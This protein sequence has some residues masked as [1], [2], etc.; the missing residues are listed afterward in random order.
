MIATCHN[1]IN[2]ICESTSTFIKNHRPEINDFARKIR[3]VAWETFKLYIAF[4]NPTITCTFIFIG[5]ALYK[6]SEEVLDSARRIAIEH[7]YLIFLIVIVSKTIL[8][9][10][11]VVSAGCIYVGARFGSN[12]RKLDSQ[13]QTPPTVTKIT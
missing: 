1:F 7:L 11:Y 12:L 2:L 6:Q 10:P 8:L 9:F 5:F 3:H 13:L 4:N